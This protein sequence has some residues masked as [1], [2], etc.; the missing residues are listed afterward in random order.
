[1]RDQDG[2]HLRIFLTVT[3]I[4]IFSKVD[5]YE[6]YI[7]RVILKRSFWISFPKFVRVITGRLLTSV[8]IFGW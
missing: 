7:F 3:I 4:S 5:R 1:M 2:L 8:P 6:I